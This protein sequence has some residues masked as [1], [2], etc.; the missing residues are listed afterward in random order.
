MKYLNRFRVPP[1]SKVKLKDIDPGFKD[2]HE[3][4]KEAAEEIEQYQKKLRSLQELLY[5][6]GRRSLLICLQGMDTAGKD[7]TINHILG[8]MNPQGCRVV[9]FKQP[10]VEELAHDFL[11]RIHQATPAQGT[12]RF[13]TA[14]ITRTCSSFASTSWSR[15]RSGPGA[16]TRSTHS[17]RN[18]S[19]PNTHI[20]KFYL[21]ISKEEQL[22]RFKERLDDPAKQWK[23]SEADY[24]ERKFWDDYMEAY[25]DVLSR[26]STKRRAVVRHPV[27]PQMVPEP[28]DRP[29]RRGTPGRA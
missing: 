28:R 29:D 15:K 1:D 16:T 4:H 5:A 23:I 21:H 18:S 26:C 8:A 2:H 12:W 24:K 9:G 14:P 17:R 3:S 13:S 6:D 10:S 7:G 22:R 11:W 19:M 27:R 20:L 25:E